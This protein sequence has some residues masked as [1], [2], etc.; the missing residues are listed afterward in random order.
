MERESLFELAH[1]KCK[2]LQ[3]VV[4]PDTQNRLIE[5]IEYLFA[6]ER[7]EESNVGL[8]KN[9]SIGAIAAREI[10]G[11]DDEAAELLFAVQSEADKMLREL[12][13]PE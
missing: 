8:L 4:P 13:K 10:D 12:I 11:I 9:V 7:G 1:R 5:Q 6:V 2:S 3:E